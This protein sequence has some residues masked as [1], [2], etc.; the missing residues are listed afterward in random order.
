MFARAEIV[1]GYIWRGGF[2]PA[3]K[4]SLVECP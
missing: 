4:R 1:V 2:P 3:L